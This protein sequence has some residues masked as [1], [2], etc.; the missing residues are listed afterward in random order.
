M[1]LIS[2][3]QHCPV[4]YDGV[5]VKEDDPPHGRSMAAEREHHSLHLKL[6]WWDDDFEIVK[7]ADPWKSEQIEEGEG[8]DVG[9][10]YI[11]QTKR[12]ISYQYDHNGMRDTGENENEERIN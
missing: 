7:M 5:A 8:N 6:L 9:L 2:D 12:I 11:R 1:L 3:D 10:E 4:P